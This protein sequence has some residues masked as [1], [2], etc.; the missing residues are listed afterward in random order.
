MS[1]ASRHLSKFPNNNLKKN[2]NIIKCDSKQI[3]LAPN[4]NKNITIETKSSNGKK[5]NKK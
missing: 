1:W 4:W 3:K 2:T 5:L